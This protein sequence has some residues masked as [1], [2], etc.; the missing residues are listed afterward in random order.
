MNSP[1]SYYSFLANISIILL[2]QQWTNWYPFPRTEQH[3][4]PTVH[5][6]CVGIEAYALATTLSSKTAYVQV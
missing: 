3:S 4:M 1:P 5:G 2:Q 6:I